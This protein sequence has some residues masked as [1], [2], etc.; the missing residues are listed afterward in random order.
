MESPRCALVVPLVSHSVCLVLCFGLAGGIR[1]VPLWRQTV[2]LGSENKS[3]RH[4][5]QCLLGF[6]TRYIFS[7]ICP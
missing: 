2:Q 7:L 4:R 3:S 1:H 6:V 5:V